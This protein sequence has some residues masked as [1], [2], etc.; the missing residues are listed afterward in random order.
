MTAAE[1][2]TRWVAWWAWMRAGCWVQ[3]AEICLDV[4]RV[5]LWAARWERMKVELMEVMR[6][7]LTGGE[8]VEWMVCP[9]AEPMVRCW[10]GWSDN[11]RVRGMV[12]MR[13]D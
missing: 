5:D 2:E 10:V 3:I 4:T 12:G 6:A 1:M 11:L 7:E 9:K 8:W 13:D